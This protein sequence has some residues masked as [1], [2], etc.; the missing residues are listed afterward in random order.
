MKWLSERISFDEDKQKVTFVI[1]PEKNGLI[2]SLMGAW[3]GMWLA[4]GGTI[5]WSLIALK[6]TQQ[7][8]VFLYVFIAFWFYYALKVGRS[9]FWIL[10]GKELIKINETSFTYKRSIK[11]YGK[12]TPYYLEN[13]KKVRIFQPK[14]KS[15]QS[16]WE[17]SPWVRGGERIEFDYM[18]KVI[19]LGRKLEEK[20]LK[21]FF[22]L[23][24]KKL[25]E[26]LRKIKT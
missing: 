1:Y 25:E 19:R 2:R 24:N 6:F 5:I 26:K 13:I 3:F 20:E 18:G 9:F 17:A 4:I 11:N 22:N 15:L 10:W 7:E 14:D 16:V 23:I 21:L 12:A 8:T